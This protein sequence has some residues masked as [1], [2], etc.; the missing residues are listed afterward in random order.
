VNNLLQQVEL[1]S[2]SPHHAHLAC[3]GI[4]TWYLTHFD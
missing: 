2:L 4:P 3:C 1:C